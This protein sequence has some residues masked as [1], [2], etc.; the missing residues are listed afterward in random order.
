MS[1]DRESDAAGRMEVAWTILPSKKQT[2][3][4]LTAA[5]WCSDSLSASEFRSSNIR[6]DNLLGFGWDVGESA[7]G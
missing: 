6:L 5:R 2:G 3:T 7:T 1:P 4:P